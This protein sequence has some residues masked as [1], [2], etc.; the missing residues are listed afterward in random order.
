MRIIHNY[1]FTSMAYKKTV[2]R[3]R[4]DRSYRRKNVKSRKVM[5]GGDTNADIRKCNAKGGLGA[6]PSDDKNYII[7]VAQR[8]GITPDGL[9]CQKLVIGKHPWQKPYVRQIIA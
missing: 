5:R 3:R 6:A 7:T 2:H 1:S 4:R 8:A 9:M